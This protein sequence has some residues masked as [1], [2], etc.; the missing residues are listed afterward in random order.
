MAHRVLHV[1]PA[2]AH[3]YGGPSAATLGMC[4][5]LLAAGTTTLIATTDADGPGRLPVSTGHV[6]L[7]DGVPT[8]FFR[9][10]L[11]ES[12]KWSAPLAR[13]VRTHA[14]E[15]DLVHIHAVFSHSSLAAGRACR[16]ARMPYVVRPLGTLDPWSLDR[17]PRRKRLLMALGVR[18]LL[19]GAAAIHYTAPQEQR[20]AE[21]RLPWL[22][23]G[24]VAPLG[25][26]EELFEPAPTGEI[27]RE[28]ALLTMARLDSKK[29]IDVLIEA[30]HTLAGERSLSNWRLIIAGDG[31]PDYVNALRTLA[32]A[33]LARTRIEFRGWVG[34]DARRDLL[35]AV[36]L[37]ALPSQQ[38]NFGIALVE[39]MACGVPVIVSPGVNL[40]A[41]LE[42]AGAGWVCERTATQLAATLRMAMSSAEQL[43]RR[44]RQARQFA[45][46]FRW[47]KV[48]E[49]LQSVYDDVLRVAASSPIAESRLRKSAL[50][51]K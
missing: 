20:L 33:G 10:Q 12:F 4:K 28:P 27:A 21:Q 32:D 30:F 15:F 35:R 25:V 26:G 51:S 24:I 40:A 46:R 29:G 38:E 6:G 14:R 5:A 49:T 23:H 22:P 11:T 16:A 44:G 34:G 39:A 2:I 8:I 9:R 19:V 48:A 41:E 47:A 43:D 36:R 42:T 1:I 7:H 45:E 3:R 31:A 37:F 50:Y 13:W 18:R 17:H